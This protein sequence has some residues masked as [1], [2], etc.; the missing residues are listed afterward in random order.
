MS[1]W[2][3]GE[4]GRQGKGKMEEREGEWCNYILME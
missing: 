4:G 2:G 3:S 1:L